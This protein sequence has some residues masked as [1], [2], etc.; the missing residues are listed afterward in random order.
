MRTLAII[1]LLQSLS[2][3]LWSQDNECPNISIVHEARFETERVI[4]SRYFQVLNAKRDGLATFSTSGEKKKGKEIWVFTRFNNDLDSLGSEEVMLSPGTAVLGYEYFQENYY[5]LLQPQEFNY[6]KLELLLLEGDGGYQKKGIS[7]LFKSSIEN[8][9]FLD[10]KVALLGKKN[11]KDNLFIKGIDDQRTLTL[12]N[13]GP[14]DIEILD[15]KSSTDKAFLSVLVKYKDNRREKSHFIKTYTAD[16]LL[17]S[18][19]RIELDNDLRIL[20]LVISE[21]ES[22]EQW[23]FGTFTNQSGDMSQGFFAKKFFGGRQFDTQY[24]Y[25]DELNNFHNWLSPKAF[26]K[27]KEKINSG[28]K[29]AHD[30]YYELNGLGLIS[31]ESGEKW[32]SINASFPNQFRK[33]D[34]GARKP[35]IHNILLVFDGTGTLSS[36]YIFK[37]KDNT[38]PR[39]QRISESGKESILTSFQVKSD[40]ITYKIHNQQSGQC[41]ESTSK[42]ETKKPGERQDTPG[43]FDGLISPWY[44]NTAYVYGASEVVDGATNNIRKIY[45][46]QKIVFK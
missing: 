1:A 28:G 13:L 30:F 6:S 31:N 20:D 38:S 44:D 27:M 45:Y 12:T 25:F 9:T 10:G 46:V 19:F 35:A 17:V 11:G 21:Y 4:S 33:D 8:F 14:P 26:K 40:K 3:S 24:L 34:N 7:T 16:G 29:D 23:I 18:D 5:L 36:D 2:I 22:G 39:W 43:V 41:P 15:I 32:L 37:L 42:I